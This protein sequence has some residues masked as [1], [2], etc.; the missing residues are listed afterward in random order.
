[1]RGAVEADRNRKTEGPKRFC[2]KARF[3][4]AQH[5]NS[6]QSSQAAPAMLHHASRAI[7][8]SPP[9]HR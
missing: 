3:R 1:M 4:V 5:R 7:E 2:S 8:R 9:K 6:P